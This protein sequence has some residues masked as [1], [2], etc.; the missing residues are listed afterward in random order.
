MFEKALAKATARREKAEAELSAMRSAKEAN[1]ASNK[2]R[3]TAEK[4][5]LQAAKEAGNWVLSGL[6]EFYFTDRALVVNSTKGQKKI[7]LSKISAVENRVTLG[8]TKF[9]VT[10]SGGEFEFDINALAVAA[11]R[12]WFLK[13]EDAVL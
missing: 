6:T 5:E 9:V 13:L 1:K 4:N 2:E 7:G 8:G 10:V 12:R 3:K 11:F